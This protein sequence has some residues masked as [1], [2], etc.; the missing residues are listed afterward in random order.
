M[1]SIFRRQEVKFVITDAQRGQIYD[2]VAGRIPPDVFGKYLVQSL[3]FDTDHW[4][5]IC[6]SIDK[7]LF[8][9]KLRLRCYGVPNLH[10]TMYLELK[11]KYR[12]I[13]H[14]RRIA[15][16]MAELEHKSV[17][18]IAA[19][20]TTQVGRELNFYLQSMPVHEKVHISYHRAAFE[21][22]SGLR[23]TFDTDVRFR[24]NLLDYQHPDGG[25][26]I[27]PPGLTVIEVKTLGGIPMWLA[28]AF[29]NLSIY[30]TSF[31]KYGV[32]YKKYIVHK[33]DR[34]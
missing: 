18:D 27:L 30:P 7:P 31:S 12:G 6:T 25:R 3:Y 10:S 33:G 19:A 4:D 22:D 32:G 28:R 5:V 8:K 14:K 13:V 20:D 23:I 34:E 11:K 1:E 26:P 15:F 21:D 2:F 9:E 29:S 24:T 16:P 17:R